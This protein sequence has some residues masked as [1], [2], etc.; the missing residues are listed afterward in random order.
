MKTQEN[1]QIIFSQSKSKYQDLFIEEPIHIFNQ[2]KTIVIM[3]LETSK[4]LAVYD[5]DVGDFLTD[6]DFDKRYHIEEVVND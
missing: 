6:E 1:K 5:K 3:S 4:I 2:G